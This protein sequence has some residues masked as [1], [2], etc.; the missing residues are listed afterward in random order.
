ML[1]K[2]DLSNKHLEERGQG[3]VEY[4]LILVLVAIAVIAILFV[5]GPVVGSV[6][7]N[8]V[9]NMG[10]SNNTITSVNA[11]RTGEGSGN[12]VIVS[13]SVSTNTTVNVSDSQDAAPVQ[14][15]PCNGSCVVTLS[16]VGFNSGQVTVVASAGGTKTANYPLKN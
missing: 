6:F 1:K 7:S 10:L 15:V 2:I 8:I 5:L 11:T 4:A 3:L 13:I 14:N 9:D 12:D 16:A